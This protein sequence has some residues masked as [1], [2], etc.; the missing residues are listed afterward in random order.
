MDYIEIIG[1]VAGILT[2]I[3][4]IPQIVRIR[5]TKSTKDLSW[6]M[7][8]VFTVGIILWLIYGA[9]IN[10]FPVIL[11]NVITLVFC[12]TILFYKFKYND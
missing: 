2:S 9:M 10:E 11:A 1:I 12:L 7:F 4:F 3:A 6:S 8:L 5:K